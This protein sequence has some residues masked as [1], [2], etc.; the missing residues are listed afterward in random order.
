MSQVLEIDLDALDKAVED[1]R[2][3][4]SLLADDESCAEAAGKIKP[5]REGGGGGSGAGGT[6]S[7][8]GCVAAGGPHGR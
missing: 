5:H 3:M 6:G 8:S 7:D 2:E 4:L 1:S